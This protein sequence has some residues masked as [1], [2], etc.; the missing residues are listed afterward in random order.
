MGV[1]LHLN[2]FEDAFAQLAS[3]ASRLAVPSQMWRS[4]GAH[5]E[6]QALQRFIDERAPD[7]N[8]WPKSL[9]ALTLGG[10]TL[11]DTARLSQSITSNADITGVEVGTNV[12]YAAI[13]Q[14]GGTITAKTPKGLRW[15]YRAGKGKNRDSWATKQSVT[16]PPRPFL[17]LEAEDPAEIVAIAVSFIGGGGN[18]AP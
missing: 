18:A 16:L 3:V 11:T 7:G 2:G 14:F 4:I 6:A 10:K 17:G 8:R 1:R 9:R 12:L 5:L 13:Q 15:K